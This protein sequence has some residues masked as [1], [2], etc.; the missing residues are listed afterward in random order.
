MADWPLLLAFAAAT[1][2]FAAVP[3]PAVLYVVTRTLA[4]GRQ[5]GVAAVLGMHLAGYFPV[6][7]TAAG[8]TA[9]LA[10]VPVI[11]AG[12]KTVGALYLIWLGFSMWRRADAALSPAAA[13]ASL[14][15]SAVVQLT[16]PKLAIFYL[17]F[18]PQFVDAG[19]AWPVGLQLLVLGIGANL[20]LGLSDLAYVWL[21][22]GLAGRL[23]AQ[24]ATL[25]RL[26]GA[27]IAGLG[28]AALVERT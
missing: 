1:F 11:Y 20:I 15:Q 12:V 28:S 23:T 17:A 26:G 6:F 19:A 18:L 25:R 3:G 21:A 22:S 16:N 9:L 13:K 5:A 2:A 14:R 8:L 7:A 24:V 10:A 4:E 27:V